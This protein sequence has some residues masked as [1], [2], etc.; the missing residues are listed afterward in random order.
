MASS[1]ETLK[2]EIPRKRP[3][4]VK[5]FYCYKS[6]Y[7]ED[8]SILHFHIGFVYFLIFHGSWFFFVSSVV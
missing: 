2:P 4:S 3:E 8:V 5:F 7:L 6:V 1:Y